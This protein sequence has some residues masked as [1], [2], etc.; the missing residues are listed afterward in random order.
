MR[1]ASCPT[2]DNNNINYNNNNSNSNIK[3]YIPQDFIYRKS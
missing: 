2:Q 3:K 1:P